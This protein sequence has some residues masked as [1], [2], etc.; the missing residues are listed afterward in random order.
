[1]TGGPFVQTK[2]SWGGKAT[3]FGGRVALTGLQDE[4][5][6]AEYALP[7]EEPDPEDD[8]AQYLAVAEEAGAA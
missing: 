5:E 6:A 2:T 7:R 3:C 4:V 1:M 8:V